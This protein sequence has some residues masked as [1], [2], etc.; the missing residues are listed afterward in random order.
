MALSTDPATNISTHSKDNIMTPNIPIT[1]EPTN[2]A[3]SIDDFVAQAGSIEAAIAQLKV[4]KLSGVKDV[5]ASIF[6]GAVTLDVTSWPSLRAFM[7][8]PV[9]PTS[10]PSLVFDD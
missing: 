6:R 3:R 7:N 5:F 8:E 1:L 2:N 4:R 9:T 10:A